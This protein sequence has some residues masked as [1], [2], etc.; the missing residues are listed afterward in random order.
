VPK[1]VGLTNTGKVR[2]NNEDTFRADAELGFYA[3]ADGMGGAEAGELASHLAVEAAFAAIG[4]TK[5]RDEQAM[6]SAFSAANE[7]VRRAA[8]ANP[9][10][11]G[12]GTTLAAVLESPAGVV[13][14]SVGDSRVYLFKDGVLRQLTEDQTWV[15]EVGRRLGLA[16]DQIRQHPM[17]HVL[18]MAIGVSDAPRI[19][20]RTIEPIPGSV[21][22]ICSD[23]LHGPVAED[24]LCGILA[25]PGD[26][27]AKC[28]SLIQAALDAGGPDNV[29]AV[30]IAF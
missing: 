7:A 15:E 10:F 28:R 19:A 17:R 9:R 6:H 8:A 5:S 14:A 13:L 22:L 4:R 25:G 24:T 27:S 1:A 29:T 16:E 3:V 11:E 2:R 23:G 30:L 20:V 12:M 26:L 21:L 18:T